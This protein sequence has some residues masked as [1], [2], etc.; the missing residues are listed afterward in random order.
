MPRPNK[1]RTVGAEARLAMRMR[2]ER[3]IRGWSTERMAKEMT[4]IGCPINQTGIWRSE[5]GDRRI[6]LDEAVAMSQLWN[7]P[8][9]RLIGE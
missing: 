7:I 5:N 9:E 6:V 2:V 1:E 4:A 8:L 3:D